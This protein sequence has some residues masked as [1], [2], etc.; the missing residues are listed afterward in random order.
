MS[1]T[2]SVRRLGTNDRGFSLLEVVIAV[3]IVTSG[4]GVVGTAIFQALSADESWRTNVVA[5]QQSRNA[6]SWFS[7]DALNA[8]TTDLVDGAP[9]SGS[10]TLSWTGTDAVPHTAQYSVSGTDLIRAFDGVNTPVAR[11]VVSAGFSISGSILTFNL[12]V[13]SGQGT[14]DST[15]LQTHLRWLQ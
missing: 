12:D 6:N 13:D 15:S 4:L 14:T 7:G 1:R 5:T 3:A 10:V 2:A 9:A 8:Q 11:T